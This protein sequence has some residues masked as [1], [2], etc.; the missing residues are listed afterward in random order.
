VLD[1][2]EATGTTPLAAAMEIAHRRVEEAAGARP[3][4]DSAA[5]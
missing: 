2:A 4:P 5:A 1:H 3:R